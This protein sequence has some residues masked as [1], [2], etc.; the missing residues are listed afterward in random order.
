MVIAQ[1][2][3]VRA[4]TTKSPK[5]IWIT[6]I[7]ISLAV[8]TIVSIV[9]FSEVTFE[10][11]E[12]HGIKVG[13]SKIEVLERL[14]KIGVHDVEPDVDNIVAISQKNL[15]SIEK[16]K[17]YD[18]ICVTDNKGFAFNVTINDSENVVIDYQSTNANIDSEQIKTKTLFFEWLRNLAKERNGILITNCIPD[19][20]RV[21]VTGIT[22][23]DRA[24]LE[25]FNAWNYSEPDSYSTVTLRFI[26][27]KIGKIEYHWRP[28]E[29]P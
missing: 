18:G 2:I 24:Y 9:F 11:D 3:E 5:I 8:I 28:Y 26:N 1:G 7:A 14:A 21:N 12:L 15:E 4:I 10:K 19:L 13:D 17:K 20:R 6:L 23:D 16:L 29:T 22:G 25:N 27:N